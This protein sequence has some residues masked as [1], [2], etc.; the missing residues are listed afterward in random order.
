MNVIEARF[1]S[2]FKKS[3]KRGADSICPVETAAPL[4]PDDQQV[5]TSPPRPVK[6][7][8]DVTLNDEDI[9]D[10]IARALFD[11]LQEKRTGNQLPA[12]MIALARVGGS[13][14]QP[15]LATGGNHQVRSSSL[16]K[17]HGEPY[18]RGYLE[19]IEYCCTCTDK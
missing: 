9:P 4:L 6:E 14:L 18:V 10:S 7:E 11:A 13:Q 17:F 19:S 16:P 3:S 2:F 1:Q 15:W 12:T 5:T 8:G